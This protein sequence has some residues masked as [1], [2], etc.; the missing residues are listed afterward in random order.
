M[1][2]MMRISAFLPIALITNRMF[3]ILIRIHL[4]LEIKIRLLSMFGEQLFADRAVHALGVQQQ[5]V[6]VEDHVGHLNVF[7]FLHIF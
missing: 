6:H 5:P 3:V 4:H 2:V 7:F 1:I